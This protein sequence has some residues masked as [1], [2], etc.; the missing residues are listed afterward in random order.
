MSTAFRVGVLVVLALVIL[1]VGV[2]LIGSKSSLFS[3][4]YIL[5]ADFQNVDGLNNG[6]EVR[7]GGIDQGTVIA[8]DL[9]A[10]PDGNMIV[11]MKMRSYTS[12]LIKTDS[13][14]SISTEGLLGDKFVDIS[15][16]STKA[17]DVG[18][19]DTIESNKTEDMAE[20][21]HQIGDQASQAIQAFRDDMEAVQHNFLLRGFFEKRGYNDS[22][23]LTAHAVP[24]LPSAKPVKEFDYASDDLF[25]KPDN[26][27]LKDKKRLD[28]AGKYLESNPFGLAVVTSSETKGDSDQ[29]QLLTE[30]RANAARDYLVQNFNLNDKHLK[31]IGLGK[32]K[33]TDNTSKLAIMVYSGNSPAAPAKPPSPSAH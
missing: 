26:A 2:F 5:K 27:E 16:G 12:N 15:F 14:A 8:I 19:G 7:L 24:R 20:Q 22:S 31:T 25:D 23:E 18:N 33:T 3:P 11:V 29:D 1:G 28:D 10:Q 17:Q 32:A 9:P 21:A 4:T 30:A 13:R 6:A